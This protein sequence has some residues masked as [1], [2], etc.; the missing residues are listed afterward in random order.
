MICLHDLSLTSQFPTDGVL[1][2][3]QVLADL[4]TGAS[5]VRSLLEGMRHA[6]I[7]MPVLLCVNSIADVQAHPTLLDSIDDCIDLGATGLV[8]RPYDYPALGLKMRLLVFRYV[9]GTPRLA[10]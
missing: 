8:E 10:L 4:T 3:F 5:G 9:P 2:A 1:C 7:S 6:G